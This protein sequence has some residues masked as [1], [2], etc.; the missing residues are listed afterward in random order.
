MFSLQTRRYF[1]KAR[2]FGH[3]ETATHRGAAGERRQG[4]FFEVELEVED[5]FVRELAFYCPRCVPAIACG[6]YLEEWL[7][8]HPLARVSELTTQQILA[9]LG[10][11]PIQRSFYAWMAIQAV[12]SAV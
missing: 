11:L 5:D 4:H 2:C 9:A 3:L 8:G 7:V 10:G 6:A 1:E 12:K